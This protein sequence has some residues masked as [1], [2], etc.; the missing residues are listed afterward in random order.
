MKRIV[1]VVLLLLLTVSMI[2]PV[3]A[4]C[5]QKNKDNESN[6]VTTEQRIEAET[7]PDDLGTFNFNGNEFKVLSVEATEGTYTTFD[8][9]GDNREDFV[10]DA[11]YRRNR[12]IENR[13][14]VLFESY[15]EKEY[16]ECFEKLK[17]EAMAA[18]EGWDLIMLINRNAYTAIQEGLICLPQD[19][20][21][22]DMSKDYYL[23]D[24]NDALT[25]D[26]IP[27][28][29]YSD[30][31]IYTFERSVCLCVNL[32]AIKDNQMAD[33]YELVNSGEW[34]FDTFFQMVRDG[35]VKDGDGNTTFW[36]CAGMADYAGTSYWF[37]CG[38]SMMSLN[39]DKTKMRFSI[40]TNPVVLEI[41]EKIYNLV[42][43]QEMFADYWRGSDTYWTTHFL[44]GTALFQNTVV[45]KIRYNRGVEGWD[46]GVLPYPKYNSEQE[47]YY[48][49]VVD[50]WLHVVPKTCRDIDRASVILEA[51][52]SGSS[53]LV[54]PAYYH[55]VLKYQ[56]MRN[57]VDI[58]MLEIIRAH[59]TFDL[60]DVT[61]ATEIRAPLIQALLRRENIA[62]FANSR[63]YTINEQQVKPLL[64]LVGTLKA[65]Q[66]Q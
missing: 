34:T 33:P 11:V 54:F 19:L 60:A 58:D 66:A 49:R 40:G 65:A 17:T 30:E 53:Q 4:S 16:Q 45:G 59:R 32:K 64:A 1:R 24:V 47:F 38:Q 43:N 26:G 15:T 48:S 18:T 35:T 22:I 29:A 28:F 12:I 20:R 31:S 55:K 61:W 37:G 41:T 42:E 36:G 23:H 51:L 25:I 5:K 14:N 44:N 50:A 27:L 56:I 7:Y 10:D 57:S 46:Y 21:Y 3:F 13:F 52:A 8:V 6:T 39:N 63:V 62:T 2:L 9:S